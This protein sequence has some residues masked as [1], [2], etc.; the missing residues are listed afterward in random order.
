MKNL[1]KNFFIFLGVFLTIAVLFSGFN[2]LNKPLE[3][4]GLETLINQI[5]N[6]E[7][8]AITINSGKLKVTLKQGKEEIIKKET[9]ETF[10]QLIKNL[11]VDSSKLKD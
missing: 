7:I 9:G 2:N 11:N 5:N 1:F 3:K 8:S 6:Q 10:S 4:V